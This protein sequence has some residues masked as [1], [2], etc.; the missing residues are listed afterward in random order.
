[1]GVFLTGLD[2]GKSRG[3]EKILG[4]YESFYGMGIHILLYI[5][6]VEEDRDQQISGCQ[7]EQRRPRVIRFL[8]RPACQQMNG[9]RRQVSKNSPCIIV[10]PQN[11]HEGRDHRNDGDAQI[12]QPGLLVAY[13][14]EAKAVEQAAD[15]DRR[16]Q[17][18]GNGADD[19]LNRNRGQGSMTDGHFND[20]KTFQ[21]VE[22]IQ[23]AK[24]QHA[25]QRKLSHRDQ[26]YGDHDVIEIETGI[27]GHHE[28]FFLQIAA[29]HH[30]QKEA[31]GYVVDDIQPYADLRLLP[32]SESDEG[33]EHREKNEN[34][35]P[36]RDNGK[37]ADLIRF[38]AHRGKQFFHLILSFRG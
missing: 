22:D 12:S 10:T 3:V 34:P 30:Q 1:M 18:Q 11:V 14:R 15:A 2:L 9:Q 26:T 38:T 5:E 35:Y 27:G 37:N 21:R 7:G 17:R 36:T 31:V 24:V 28:P 19:G 4:F 25:Q 32:N 6:G 20:G 29:D 8:V 33:Q 23:T 16:E 13:R